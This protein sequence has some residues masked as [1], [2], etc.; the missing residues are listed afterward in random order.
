MTR[1]FS[2]RLTPPG[3]CRK[4]ID[5]KTLTEGVM[6]RIGRQ[7]ASISTILGGAGALALVGPKAGIAATAPV[8]KP[9]GRVE[10]ILSNNGP[11]TTGY[12]FCGPKPQNPTKTGPQKK[13]A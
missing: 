12:A 8:K 5:N 13:P 11:K 3:P 2:R 9:A 10:G 6:A 7:G 4:H 1:R